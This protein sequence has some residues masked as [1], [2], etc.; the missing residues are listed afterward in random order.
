VDGLHATIVDSVD[1]VR[2]VRSTIC[3][4]EPWSRTPSGKG[5]PTNDVLDYDTATV[6]E[7]GLS[8]CWVGVDVR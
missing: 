1:G 3:L 4:F 7:S 6:A 5:D 2:E 8:M